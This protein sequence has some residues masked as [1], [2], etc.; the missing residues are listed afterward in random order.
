MATARQPGIKRSLT[1]HFRQANHPQKPTVGVP[2]TSP[3][4]SKRGFQV[5][6]LQTC[7]DSVRFRSSTVPSPDNIASNG[8]RIWNCETGHAP[9]NRTLFQA[10]FAH[11]PLIFALFRSSS[12]IFGFRTTSPQ[13]LNDPFGWWSRQESNLR[14]SHCERADQ[15][16]KYRYS[17]WI[18]YRVSAFLRRRW[19]C[20]A[21]HLDAFCQNGL[22]TECG[23]KKRTPS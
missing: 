14:P 5:P 20:S 10:G 18:C 7:G 1:A 21:R 2:Y 17:V 23:K 4:G 8:G 11:K 12:A 3:K 6:P 15:R 13:T 16:C 19:R 9:R 22:L